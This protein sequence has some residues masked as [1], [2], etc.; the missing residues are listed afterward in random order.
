MKNNEKAILEEMKKSLHA[1]EKDLVEQVQKRK[2][3]PTLKMKQTPEGV[4]EVEKNKK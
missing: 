4:W 1:M 3:K 2:E